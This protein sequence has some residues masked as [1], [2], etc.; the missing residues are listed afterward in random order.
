MQLVSLVSF[1]RA[2]LHWRNRWTNS[3]SLLTWRSGGSVQSD[4]IFLLKPPKLSFPLSSSQGLIILMLSLLALLR[5]FLIKFKEWSTAHLAT[6]SKFL[7]LPTVLFYFTISTGYQSQPDSIQNSSTLL[8]HCL[9]YSSSIPLRV[10]HL[11][12]PCSFRSASDTRASV[13]LGWAAGPWGRDPFNTL[14]LWSGTPFLCQQFVF[15]LF[16]CKIKFSSSSSL[17][18]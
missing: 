17:F 5:V 15:T 14:D 18:L 7:N 3:V 11:Y 6:F 10:T 1:L 13:F 4:S 2:C 16:S 9:W 12:S 8:P